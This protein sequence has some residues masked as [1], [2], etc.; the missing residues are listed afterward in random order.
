[1]TYIDH[2]RQIPEPYDLGYLF[3]VKNGISTRIDRVEK[4]DGE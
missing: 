4:A 3:G 1:M 2:P